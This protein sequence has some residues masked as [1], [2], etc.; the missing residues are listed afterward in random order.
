GRRPRLSFV[1]VLVALATGASSLVV[2]PAAA[3]AAAARG[4]DASAGP[5]A[6]VWL[7]PVDGAVARPFVE[8]PGPYGPG[9]PGVDLAVARST[10]VRASGD[11]VV[12]FAGPV[13]G[14]LHVVVAHDGGLR[15][16]YSFLASVAVHAGQNVRRGDVLGG[17]GGT[18][19]E[20]D[21]S[22]LHFGLRVGD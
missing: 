6:G 9:H 7:R 19:E 10:P 15:T 18:G 2:V 8:P 13:A 12:T 22:V 5:A 4:A 1:I 11:G 17:A 16:S 20:H 3:H 14:S 21:G